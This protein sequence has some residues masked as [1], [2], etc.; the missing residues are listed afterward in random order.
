MSRQIAW[1]LFAVAIVLAA[2][3]GALIL[4]SLDAPLPDQWG[5]R[6][7]NV[8]FGP[9]AQLGCFSASSFLTVERNFLSFPLKGPPEAVR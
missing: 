1:T 5:F 9:I 6:G 3:G 8:I 2:A 4:L 7:Y